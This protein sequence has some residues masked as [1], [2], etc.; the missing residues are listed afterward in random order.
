ML[1]YTVWSLPF[2]LWMLQ[3]YIAASPTSWR[4]RR[5]W[6]APAGSRI[7]RSILLPLLAPGLVATSLFTFISAWNEFFFALVLIQDPAKK[8][9]PLTLAN[10]VGQE[11]Q[12]Q[13]PQLAAG[14][15]AG[16][17]PEP[18]V[19]RHHPTPPDVRPPQRGREGM[20]R[21]AS[22]STGRPPLEHTHH[23]RI[24]P[25]RINKE[26]HMKH[27]AW[28]AAAALG[29]ALA[30]VATSAGAHASGDPITLKFQSLAF[31]DSTIAAT[32]AIVDAW[33]TA[34]PDVQ[35]EILQGS[36]TTP[37]TSSPPSSPAAR[38]RT[39]STSSRPP[40]AGSP[41]RAISPTCRPT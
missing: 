23:P 6:T 8:T 10:F 25:T 14:V 13:L 22:S 16:H 33:N 3:G 40:S 38:H 24:N 37:A 2:A 21:D 15:A 17:H 30:G 11:G 4:R 31:Q 19:L 26:Q 7:L 39:S 18:A 9:L 27:K 36:W 28:G 32:Q 1:V 29:I 35:V 5:R 34:N 12:V 20:T 41:S